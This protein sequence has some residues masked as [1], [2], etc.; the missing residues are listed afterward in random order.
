MRYNTSAGLNKLKPEQDSGWADGVRYFPTHLMDPTPKLGAF[1][2]SNEI[3]I[4]PEYRLY[5]AT[6]NSLDY[7]LFNVLPIDI[8]PHV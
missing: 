8:K 7:W 3:K 6:L 1:S 4:K 5:I 2:L